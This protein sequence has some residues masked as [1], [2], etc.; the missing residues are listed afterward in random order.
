MN[1]PFS[2]SRIRSVEF[3]V[4]YDTP[5][6]D[7]Y[8]QIPVGEDVQYALEEML[9]TTLERLEVENSDL[10][11][12]SISQHYGATERL[13]ADLDDELMANVRSIY[14]LENIEAN[15]RVLDEPHRMVFYLAAFRDD[16]GRKLLGIRRATQFKGILKARNR[17][18]SLVDDSLK[19]VDEDIFRLDQDFDF[20]VTA[21]AVLILRPSGFEYVAGVEQAASDAAVETAQK[22]E[23]TL[24]FVDFSGVAQF[25]ATHRRAARLIGSIRMRNDLSRTSAE[26]VKR[27]CRENGIGFTMVKGKIQPDEGAEMEFLELLDRRRYH[28]DLAGEEELYVAPNRRPVRD[29]SK[30]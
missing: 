9:T 16:R 21:K 17:L 25:V 20:V 11:T 4:C 18:V 19:L 15:P 10:E 13:T 27:R 24:G 22:I 7:R 8:W 30:Q 6:G 5:A 14:G 26:R 1:L 23:K 28:V 2:L 12:F 29:Q 3:F